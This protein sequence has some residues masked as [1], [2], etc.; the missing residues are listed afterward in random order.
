MANPDIQQYIVRADTYGFSPNTDIV[1]LVT[2]DFV[3]TLSGEELAQAQ[4]EIDFMM[5]AT[6]ITIWPRTQRLADRINE[7]DLVL[8]TASS[9]A[10]SALTAA[11][12]AETAATSAA[13]S[14]SAAAANASTATTDA[15]A[16]QASVNALAAIECRATI[17]APGSWGATSV[18][19]GSGPETHLPFPSSTLQSSPLTRPGSRFSLANGVLT[20]EPAAAGVYR[21]TLRG[22]LTTGLVLTGT[23]RIYL[24]LGEDLGS[25]IDY[26]AAHVAQI[27]LLSSPAG[28]HGSGVI[29]IP[30]G[31]CEIAL[32]GGHSGALATNLT[33]ADVELS[34]ERVGLLDE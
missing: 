4:L 2:E 24:A 26:S 1:D 12:A 5:F 25:A 19:A 22:S 21:Y 34:L 23:A 29:V 20:A 27:A 11:S 31:G 8:A 13:S 18:A 10:S 16:A 3:S 15:A 9:N 33:L 28:V 32:Y 7:R 14:A 17:R 30:E 6:H